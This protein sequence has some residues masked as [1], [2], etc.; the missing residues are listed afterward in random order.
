MNSRLRF[1]L[2]YW[3]IW[4]LFSVYMATMDFMRHAKEHFFDVLI[5]MNLLQNLIWGCAGLVVLAMARRWPL[6]RL[7]WTNCRN[8]VI[9]L[10]GSVVISMVSLWFV[11]LLVIVF[12]PPEMQQKVLADPL[13]NYYGFFS[14]YFHINLLLMWAVLGAYHGARI[15]GLSRKQELEAAQLQSRLA[16]AQNRALQMQLQPHFLFNTLNS[17]AAL[18]HSD[19]EAADKMLTRLADLL[20]MTLDSGSANEISLRQE[21]AFTDTYLSIEAIR[22]QDRLTIQRDVPFD[23]MDALVPAFLLQPLV[24][25]AVKHGVANL[26]RSATITIR[27]HHDDE[28]LILD[29]IDNGCGINGNSKRGIG[30]RNTA[31]RL[32]LMYQNRHAFDMT[33]LPGGGAQVTV[34]IPW[35][36]QPG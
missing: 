26:A 10:T 31:T 22:F 19:Q 28:W 35:R 33:N 17:I 11:W 20:R 27:A 36:T 9:H 6:A 21:M 3:G 23:C 30:T 16:I 5:P 15:L 4:A 32:Q 12:S 7:N 25:N 8:W 34:R 24:E 14:M 13:S 29:V 1:W 2:F 18:I